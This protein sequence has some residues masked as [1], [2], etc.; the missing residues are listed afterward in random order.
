[1]EDKT[2][3]L[4]AIKEESK[5]FELKPKDN[6]KVCLGKGVVIV[7]HPSAM[8][9]RVIEPCQCVKKTVTLPE[10]ELRFSLEKIDVKGEKKS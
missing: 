5:T 1:M 7:R 3:E 10:S 6:C 4:V 8:N 2:G 9:V